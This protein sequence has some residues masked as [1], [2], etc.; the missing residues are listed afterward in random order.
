MKIHKSWVLSL[1]S[2]TYNRNKF[3]NLSKER[4]NFLLLNKWNNLFIL[5]GC[6]TRCCCKNVWRKSKL[7]IERKCRKT[8]CVASLPCCIFCV[9]SLL[10][11]LPPYLIALLTWG[12]LW[13]SPLFPPPPPKLLF[14]SLVLHCIVGLLHISW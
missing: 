10:C 1:L 2:R 12:T 3:K 9:A 7:C 6:K 8:S 14:H 4:I 5:C 13:T 11:V